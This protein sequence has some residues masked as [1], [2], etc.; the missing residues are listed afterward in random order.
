MTGPEPRGDPSTADRPQAEHAEVRV[1]PLLGIPEVLPHH[2]LAAL[3]RAALD[4]AGLDLR[5]GDVVVVSSKIVSKAQGLRVQLG[6]E[7]H[8]G[9]ST[10]ASPE[11]L[12]L[13]QTARV[14]AER[15]TPGGMT[16]IVAAHAGPVLAGAG[17]DQS[18]TGPLGGS[19]VLPTDPD[20]AARSVYA[21]LLRAY[22]P[23]P[24]PQIAVVISDTAGRPWREGQVD[25]ALGA[26]GVQVLDDLR[27]GTHV[28]VDG[29]PLQ[30]TARA[31][32]DEI[33]AAADLVKGKTSHIPA[34][35]VRGLP[36][37]LIGDP[38]AAGAGSMVRTGTADWFALG[39]VEA[40][41]SSL[42]APPGT[43]VAD[44]VGVASSGPEPLD[45]RAQRAVDV[46]LVTD[47]PLTEPDSVLI[48]DGV[49]EVRIA[50]AYLRG[51]IVARVEV[52]LHSEHLAHYCVRPI[53]AAAD[54]RVEP[55]SGL[56]AAD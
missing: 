52:A 17:V 50:D 29:R 41:R 14:V 31:V 13:S 15:R 51:R 20:G 27:G 34:A 48:G 28:D 45:V 35:L 53:S 46:A 44:Q 30:V 24:L 3:L 18:N 56:C 7:E 49:I 37:S 55:S 54:G 8:R 12:V 4:G 43:S 23:S 22:A 47:D 38:R 11:S 6:D 9:G 25:F 42:A 10:D 26:C 40:V 39:T 36:L 21:G 5:D 1:V 32:A 19:L 33:A 2:D 16:R